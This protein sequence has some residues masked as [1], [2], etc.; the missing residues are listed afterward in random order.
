M[1]MFCPGGIGDKL[2]GKKSVYYNGGFANSRAYL[3]IQF[4]S[5]LGWFSP[6]FCSFQIPAVWKSTRKASKGAI[7]FS[8]EFFFSQ[9]S[10][11]MDTSPKYP[12]L[13]LL[14]YLR[15]FTW[16]KKKSI[17][18][19]EWVFNTCFMIKPVK[20][21]RSHDWLRQ[22]NSIKFVQ[23]SFQNLGLFEEFVQISYLV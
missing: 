19:N 23:L 12:L 2:P 11:N 14:A 10:P 4:E 6:I 15:Q 1:W 17:R 16:C 9:P 3:V 20:V 5:L 21:S 8:M 13:V 22:V 18:F 7:F